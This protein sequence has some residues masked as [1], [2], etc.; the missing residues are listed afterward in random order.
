M[1][2]I[3]KVNGVCTAKVIDKYVAPSRK[4]PGEMNSYYKLDGLLDEAIIK[5]SHVKGESH[6]LANWRTIYDDAE[7]DDII[8]FVYGESEFH[9][10]GFVHNGERIHNIRNVSVK[11]SY[12]VIKDDKHE[13]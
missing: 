11:Q 1:R 3:H 5:A 6:W 10:N 9:E 2:I 12:I 13:T 7:I 8:H 4:Y